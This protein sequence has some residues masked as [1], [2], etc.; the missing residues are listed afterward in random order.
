MSLYKNYF[1]GVRVTVVDNF[2]GEENDII[3]LSLVRSERIGFLKILNRVCV[4]LSR[5]RKGFYIVGNAT[6]LARDSDL[7]R[8]IFA[9]MRQEEKMGNHLKLTCQNHSQNEI[10]ASCA[11]DFKDA[12]EGGCKES[13]AMK[14]DCGHVCD[15]KCHPIDLEHKERFACQQSCN[16][17]CDFGHKC[18]MKCSEECGPCMVQVPKIIPECN[19]EQQIPCS[20]DPIQFKCRKVVPRQ[21]TPCGHVNEVKCCAEIIVCKE[22]CGTLECGHL[23]LGKTRSHFQEIFCKCDFFWGMYNQN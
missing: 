16:K 13:C 15:Q 11:E 22:P 19:H 18:S 2:Q 20:V 12:P 8:N 5:A 1:E 4:A 14:L 21:A 17:T 6:L 9:D 3:L 10:N 7:W 23:C